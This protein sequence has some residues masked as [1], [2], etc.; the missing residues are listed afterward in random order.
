MFYTFMHAMSCHQ[1]ERIRDRD[2]IMMEA[3]LDRDM[4]MMEAFLKIMIL[5]EFVIRES[6]QFRE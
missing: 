3:F 1:R 2:M 6:R 4:I 5:E